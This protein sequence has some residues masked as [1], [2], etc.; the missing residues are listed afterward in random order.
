M[1]VGENFLL[2]IFF[3]DQTKNYKK[4]DGRD[5]LAGILLDFLATPLLIASSDKFNFMQA[6]W[7]LLV[8]TVYKQF[9][10]IWNKL[11]TFKKFRIKIT[12]KVSY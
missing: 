2:I 9:L 8:A 6:I 1:L 4:T 10:L 12:Q 3:R 11:K 5:V 7:S